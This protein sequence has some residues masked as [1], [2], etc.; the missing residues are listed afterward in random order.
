MFSV[1]LYSEIWG[2]IEKPG[3]MMGTQT[4]IRN[5]HPSKTMKYEK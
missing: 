3:A 4:L 2:E 5:E 1:T